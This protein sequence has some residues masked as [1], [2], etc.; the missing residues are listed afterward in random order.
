MVLIPRTE[1]VGDSWP[2]LAHTLYLTYGKTVF[3]F[4]VFLI[5]LPSLLGTQSIIRFIMDTKMFNFVA[6]VSYCTYLLHLCFIYWWDSQV[7]TNLYYE[8]IGVYSLFAS[9]SV[10]SVLGGFVLAVLVE[11]PCAKFQKIIIHKLLGKNDRK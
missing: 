6:K 4:S 8:L 2:Q 7:S 11:I 10:I 3:V 5:I 1:Q 9:H